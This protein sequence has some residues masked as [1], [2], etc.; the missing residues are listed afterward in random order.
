MSINQNIECKAY[1]YIFSGLN[2]LDNCLNYQLYFVCIDLASVEALRVIQ[3]FILVSIKV[4]TFSWF[5]EYN[6]NHFK[7]NGISFIV[8]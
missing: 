1:E 6:F 4:K 2:Y 8:P 5:R 7:G 3:T